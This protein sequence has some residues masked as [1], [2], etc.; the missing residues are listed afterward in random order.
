METVLSLYA[1]ARAFMAANGNPNQWG[2][3]NPP[4]K[5]LEEDVEKGNLYLL[6]N[7]TGIHG[8]FAFL[9][10][11]DPT[12]RTIWEGAWHWDRP[13][14][15]IHRVAGDGSHGILK[16]AVSYGEQFADYLR[17]DTHGDNLPMQGAILKQGFS[18]CGIIR[19]AN[20]APRLAYDRLK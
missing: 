4:R 18:Y 9:L 7:E 6:F 17:I 1:G 13:Y 2:K 15:V 14:G 20:G 3:T 5:T 10:E 8:V 11:P 16:G 12:Y 19:L